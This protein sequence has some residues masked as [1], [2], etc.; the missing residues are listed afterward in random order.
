MERPIIKI[1][2][3]L[4][5][6][7]NQD[8]I[9]GRIALLLRSVQ[10]SKSDRNSLQLSKDLTQI[11]ESHTLE[12]SLY[13]IRRLIKGLTV[14]KTGKINDLNLNRWKE[15]DDIFTDSLWIVD[16]RDRTGLHSAEYWGNFI[17][18]IPQQLLRR[19][20]KKGDWVL[21]PFLGSGTTLIECRK[22]GR[23]GLGIEI[24]PSL[25]KKTRTRVIKEINPF[26]TRTCII[27]GDSAH[28]DT[29]QLLQKQ[30]ISSVQ[31]ALL[32]PPY[33]D[34]IHFSKN[35]NDLS[36]AKTLQKFLFEFGNVVKNCASI[37]DRDR[38]LAVVISDKYVD[39]EWIPLGFHTMQETLKH[40]FKLKSIIIKNFNQTKAKRSQEELW[41]YRALVG[42]FYVFKH[43][44]IFLFQKE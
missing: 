4:L 42:G 16:K 43:E 28:I 30:H 14:I 21:D 11:Y 5:T 3:N 9:K 18:Q 36:N 20:T 13:Y 26:N 19:Y 29:K 24:Q 38:Y 7:Q 40:G 6:K 12:R 37:L 22:L 35:K 44:Y 23:N 32:H 17:P 2:H 33:W 39:R 1:L 27:T 34:I 8:E 31:F 10:N 41:R 25:A 15:Y